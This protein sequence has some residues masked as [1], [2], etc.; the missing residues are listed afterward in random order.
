MPNFVSTIATKQS[1]KKSILKFRYNVFALTRM[2]RADAVPDDLMDPLG[3][4][5]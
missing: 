3:Y 2:L 1:Q 5:R 4:V